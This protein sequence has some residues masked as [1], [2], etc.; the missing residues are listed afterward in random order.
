MPQ[1]LR[2]SLVPQDRRETEA[3]REV[4]VPKVRQ[5]LLELQELL[6]SLVHQAHKEA[7]DKAV[8]PG[9]QDHQVLKVQLD[10]L[11]SQ[12]LKVILDP[13]EEPELQDQLVKEVNKDRLDQPEQQARRVH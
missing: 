2:D 4:R 8:Q 6:D 12:V 1:G 10:Q 7:V 9:Q 11:V 13:P 3:R 5:V